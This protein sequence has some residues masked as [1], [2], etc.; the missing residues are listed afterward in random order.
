MRTAVAHF[1]QA[2][3]IHSQVFADGLRGIYAH[4]HIARNGSGIAYALQ[5]VADLCR[6]ENRYSRI[7]RATSRVRDCIQQTSR[8]RNNAERRSQ[9]SQATTR[10][11]Q[12]CRPTKI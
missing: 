2:M 10:R 1:A 4:H 7:A 6:P 12:Q 9:M 8:G 11:M 5:Y 3:R